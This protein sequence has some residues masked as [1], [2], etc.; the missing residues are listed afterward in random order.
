MFPRCYFPGGGPQS[1]YDWPEPDPTGPLM[2]PLSK[3]AELVAA[4]PTFRV[5]CGLESNDQYAS[6]KLL[7]GAYGTQKRI[8]YPAADT[9]QWDIFPGI[10]LAQ[11]DKWTWE[12]AKYSQRASGTL[13]MMIF[14]EDRYPGNLEATYRDFLSFAGNLCADLARLFSSDDDLAGNAITQ[15]TAPHLPPVEEEASRGKG[16]WQAAY[17]IGWSS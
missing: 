15:V 5:R 8:F 3:L 11:G 10:V 6:A 7:E 16:Y 2:T 12:V 13:L 17:N 14:D 9:E 4:S 1:D